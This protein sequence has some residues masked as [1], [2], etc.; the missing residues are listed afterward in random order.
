MNFQPS[1]VNNWVLKLRLL[2]ALASSLFQESSNLYRKVARS[3]LGF[4]NILRVGGTHLKERKWLAEAYNLHYAVSGRFAYRIIIPI[5]DRLGK[6]ATWTGRAIDREAD[7][8]YLTLK[9]D[10]ARAAPGELL[11]GPSPFV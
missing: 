3:R 10:E 11:L 5:T 7:I 2:V 9:T 4:G 8:R 6:V 1:G